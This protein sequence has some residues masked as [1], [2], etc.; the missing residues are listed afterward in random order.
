MNVIQQFDHSQTVGV[1]G[2]GHIGLPTAVGL[3]ELGWE[4]IGA[5]EDAEK[6]RLIQKG[7]P[8]FFEPGLDALLAKHSATGKFRVT[9]DVVEAVQSASVLFVCV[10]TPQRENGASDLSQVEQIARTIGKSLNGYKL[11]VEK[12][13]V[14]AIT[15]LWIERTVGRYA[16]ARKHPNGQV[17][18]KAVLPAS[19]EEQGPGF[20]VASNPEFLQE[21]TAIENFFHPSRI[22]IGVASDRARRILEAIYRPLHCPIVVTDVTTAELIK[23]S[24]NAF[25][26]TKISFINMVADICDA[27]GADVQRVAEGLGLD[28]RI[29]PQFLQAGIGFGG[30]CLPKDLRSFIHLIEENGLDCALLHAAERI[31]R[32][33]IDTFLAKVRESLW[34]LNGKTVGILGLAFKPGTDDMREAPS[35]RIIESFLSEGASL[36]LHDPKAMP[37]ARRLFQE[38]P[39]KITY[40]ASPYDVARGAQAVLLITE[41]EEYRQLDLAALRELMEVPVLLDGRN[42]YDPAQA[43]QA[44]FEYVCMGRP[45]PKSVSEWRVPADLWSPPADAPALA[46]ELLR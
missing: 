9:C 2:L 28:P 6:I 8:P 12:S 24:A 15:A 16:L 23:H 22:I 33:R 1:L 37:T 36:R 34:I 43:R 5:D 21:G 31:N 29:G 11:I 38:N 35:I 20:E 25:L 7:T 39:G 40:C 32:G 46:G 4:V 26:A 27:L 44:G 19:Q 18:R 30:Y 13:T 10:G 42:L 14:P 45:A 3:A 41:W 17:G